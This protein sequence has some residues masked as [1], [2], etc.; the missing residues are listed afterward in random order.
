[1]PEQPEQQYPFGPPVP[2]KATSNRPQEADDSG[3]LRL[4]PLYMPLDDLP[5]ALFMKGREG[6]VWHYSVVEDEHEVDG[7]IEKVPAVMLGSE[8]V[9][10]VL[11]E[12]EQNSL[13]AGMQEAA[14]RRAEKN[15]D[16]PAVIPTKEDL[17]KGINKL[18]HPTIAAGFTP[19]GE[20]M[21]RKAMIS[22]EVHVFPS[23]NLIMINDKS[24]RYM[25]EKV[26]PGLDPQEA[27]K[28]GENVRRLFSNH[29]PEVTVQFQ[30]I[31]TLAPPENAAVAQIA[32]S[33][34]PPA[35]PGAVGGVPR[36]DAAATA[37]PLRTDPPTTGKV[38]RR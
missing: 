17:E 3:M 34:L 5:N 16:E 1:M 22:G 25:S 24:G 12:K 33:G 4:N 37:C 23:K 20:T 13:L 18:G 6:A 30:Q 9:L 15:P 10:T 31:K 35:V 36:T 21:V 28:W 19:N 7:A 2:P 8:E 26:R 32:K 11:A 27:A 29:F 38:A 14:R